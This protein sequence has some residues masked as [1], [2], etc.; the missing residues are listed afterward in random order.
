MW[1]LAFA[2]GDGPVQLLL[3]GDP[4]PLKLTQAP[5]LV[6]HNASFEF[7]IIQQ[8]LALRHGWPPIPLERFFCTQAACLSLGLPAKLRSVA[9][10]LELTHRKDAAGER[11]MHQ[12]SKPRKPRKDEDPAGTYWHDD[13]ERRQRLYAYCKQD[14]EVARELYYRLAHYVA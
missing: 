8:N 7:T 10:V 5:R 14:V 6:A 3:P 9:D 11:L 2:I 1:C 12:M 4:A 13:P